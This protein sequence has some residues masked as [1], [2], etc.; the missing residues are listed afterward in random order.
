MD[1]PVGSNVFEEIYK[2]YDSGDS[3]IGG[4][5][6]KIGNIHHIKITFDEKP[7]R[8]LNSGNEMVIGNNFTING[9]LITVYNPI[10]MYEFDNRLIYTTKDSLILLGDAEGRVNTIHATVDFLYEIKIDIY[11]QKRIE[12]REIKR[13]IGQFFEE[14]KPDENIY[15]DI[16]YK[17]HIEWD[18][19]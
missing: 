13:G 9:R 14:C 7:L 18:K 4:Y 11:E 1:F 3:N 2:K 16:Y 5:M 6:K 15:N 17:Y 8:I 10:R 12:K 19:K